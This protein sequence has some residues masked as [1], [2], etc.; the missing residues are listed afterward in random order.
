PTY[1]TQWYGAG[2]KEYTV[3]CALKHRFTKDIV[4]QFKLGYVNSKNQTTGGNTNF[5]GP[6][7]Y[8][9]FDYAI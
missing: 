4:G 3:T 6:L 9:S 7:A 5:K 1:A 2:V 8:V